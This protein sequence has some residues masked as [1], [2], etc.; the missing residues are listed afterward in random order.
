MAAP[1]ASPRSRSAANNRRMT[2]EEFWENL[3]SAMSAAAFDRS[4]L[5]ESLRDELLERDEDEVLDFVRHFHEARIEAYRWDLWAAA[6]VAG[7][8]ATEQDFSDFRD[9]L[10][11]LGREAYDDVLHDPERLLN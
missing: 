7:G 10:I 1:A 4:R 8:G 5:A 11:S 9:W 3:D 6:W 2:R